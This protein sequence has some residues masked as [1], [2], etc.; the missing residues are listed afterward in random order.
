MLSFELYIGVGLGLVGI[1]FMNT[2]AI[3]IREVQ[4]G[5]NEVKRDC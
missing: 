5:I 1:S 3:D 2:V 4:R